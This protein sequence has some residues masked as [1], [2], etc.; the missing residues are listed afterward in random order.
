M[1][2]LFCRQRYF[3]MV[4]IG[5]SW[6]APAQRSASLVCP[7]FILICR[8]R[9]AGVKPCVVGAPRPALP[10][11]TAAPSAIRFTTRCKYRRSRGRA[12]FASWAHRPPGSEGVYRIAACTSSAD[13]LR[14]PVLLPRTAPRPRR[15]SAFDLRPSHGISCVVVGTTA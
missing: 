12:D 3:L 5:A 2:Y 8:T 11:R 6:R 15:T 7:I 13:V 1:A 10:R 14:R 4:S 9:I